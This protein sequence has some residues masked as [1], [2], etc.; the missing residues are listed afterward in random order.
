[1]LRF[2]ESCDH[3]DKTST[4]IAIDESERDEDATIHMFT[5]STAE[6]CTSQKDAEEILDETPKLNIQ[7]EQEII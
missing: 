2:L 3:Q 4:N 6:N 5:T 7:D 1:M